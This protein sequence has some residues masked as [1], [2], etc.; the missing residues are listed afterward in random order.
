MSRLDATLSS[1][2]G[3]LK[4]GETQLS[5]HGSASIW[6]HCSQTLQVNLVKIDIICKWGRCQNWFQKVDIHW[7]C[8]I[9]WQHLV[10][11]EDNVW[12]RCIGMRC[13]LVQPVPGNRRGSEKSFRTPIS[14]T[15]TWWTILRPGSQKALVIGDIK[16]EKETH[17]VSEKK[18]ILKKKRQFQKGSH[19]KRQFQKRSHLKKAVVRLRKRSC[20]A[21]SHSW[22]CRGNGFK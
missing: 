5:R 18:M 17:S 4:V 7:E 12:G 20:P 10:S 6:R 8:S 9:F 21:V 22:S 16:D 2:C 1:C 14:R 19:L 13:Q 15:S 3:R 11:A